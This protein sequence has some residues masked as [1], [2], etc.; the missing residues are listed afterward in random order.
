MN[1]D[2]RHQMRRC[3]QM[4]A[5]PTHNSQFRR[6]DVLQH[7][8]GCAR[9]GGRGREGEATTGAFVAGVNL[10]CVCHVIN[11]LPL[12]HATAKFWG[13]EVDD[14]VVGWGSRGAPRVRRATTPCFSAWA[15]T[16]QR[17][18]PAGATV[19]RGRGRRQGCG[20]DLIVHSQPNLSPRK[21]M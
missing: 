11:P 6:S 10:A 17:H 4:N 1:G 13:T 3:L 20:G 5:G 21:H 18:Y 12:L 9:G 8:S 14:K 15:Q 16:T 19:A 2:R 7:A